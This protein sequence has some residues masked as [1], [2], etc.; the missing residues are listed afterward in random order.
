MSQMRE[1]QS[2]LPHNPFLKK[3]PQAHHKHT[4]PL[5]VAFVELIFDYLGHFQLQKGISLIYK[6]PVAIVILGLAL[7]I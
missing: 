5:H 3:S 1:L 6:W 7:V 2:R 4:N